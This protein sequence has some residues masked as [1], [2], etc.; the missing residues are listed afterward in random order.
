MFCL[1]LER[2]VLRSWRRLR[3]YLLRPLFLS[4]GERFRFDP[5]GTYSFH[6]ISVGNNVNLGLRPFLSS[7]R[8]NIKIGNHVFFGPEVAIHGG[9]HRIDV[10]GRFMISITEDEKRTEDDKDV[11][12]EDDVWIGTR[13]IILHG[14]TI[15]RGAVVAA[16]AVVT[17][18]VPPY[19]IV[20]GVPARVLK[21][22]WDVETIM[23]HEQKLYVPD[24]C[25]SLQD[26]SQWQE[27]K[28]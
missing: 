15:G 16:G 4:Y 1:E 23:L 28:L 10:V 13:A 25:V 7:T 9:N 24:E 14:V 2:L 8:S 17:R 12:I 3:E 11:I 18:D 27:S 22:R 20:G 5:D 19:S 6:N 21:F 26:L